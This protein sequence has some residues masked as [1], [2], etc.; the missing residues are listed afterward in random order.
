MKSGAAR[1]L[2]LTGLDGTPVLVECQISGG[3]PAINLVGLPDASLNE[4]LAR[5]RAAIIALGLVL[6]AARV[7]INLSP[8]SIPKSGSGYDLAISASLLVAMGNLQAE[9]VLSSF[10]LGE[11]G[12]DG[13]L[14]PVRGVLATVAAIRRSNP[15]SWIVVPFENLREAM[16]VPGGRV[17]GLEHLGQLIDLHALNDS[18]K[19]EYERETLLRLP[20][21]SVN[22][23]RS[24]ASLDY[25]QVI[26]QPNAIG[27]VL[28]AA[29]GGH[30]LLMVG[31]PGSGKTMLAERLPTI[32]PK[33]NAEESIESTAIHSIRFQ[34]DNSK[35]LM[36]TPPFV[37][38]HHSASMA[39][40]VGGGSR[41]P[42]PGAISLAHNGVLFL[43]E[44]T[45]FSSHVLDSLRQPLESGE[46]TVSRAKASAT[47]PSR[48]Q[49]VMAANPCA[50]GNL[51]QGGS[52]RCT[53]PAAVI[54]RYRSKLSGP[55]LD[56]VDIHIRVQKPLLN[57][58]IRQAV[59]E[60][61]SQELSERVAAARAIAARRFQALPWSINANAPASWVREHFA[62]EQKLLAPLRTRL[63]R[64]EISMR[65]F[66]RI[67]RVAL[68]L[69][70][71]SG[72]EKCTPELIESATLLRDPDLVGRF[73]G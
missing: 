1:A 2:S 64:G 7:T 47:F 33:L 72:D 10:H 17:I 54:S 28:V 36:A 66:T 30:N 19:N 51:N 26:G 42:Q 49:L 53:C 25:S 62:S 15:Q 45:E 6:P 8:A 13:R 55:L 39:S 32:L 57:A 9:S 70:D 61:S 58:T 22:H 38:P 63:V 69:T 27:A 5:V 71:L 14:R 23:S 11:L 18:Q 67:L 52:Q 35:P 48:F 73:R 21:E 65:G 60:T 46:V 24:K 56:R 50:C 41:E 29:A 44:A 43:D 3:L 20:A 68:T 31:P 37:A 59:G 4:S 16:L 12:L 40:L 34:L